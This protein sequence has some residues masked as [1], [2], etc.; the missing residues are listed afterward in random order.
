MSKDVYSNRNI[1]L[2]F[3]ITVSLVVMLCIF[4][5]PIADRLVLQ[6]NIF[7]RYYYN[8]RP[9]IGAILPSNGYSGKNLLSTITSDPYVP[10][11]SL[12]FPEEG[13]VSATGEYDKSNN[14]IQISR[15]K[16][17]LEDGEYIFTDGG[18]TVN[19]TVYYTYIAGYKNGEGE[20]VA[21]LPDNNVFVADGLK[22]D[23]YI[24]YLK[25][26]KGFYLDGVTFYPMIRKADVSDESFEP[27]VENDQGK[28]LVFHIHKKDYYALSKL[29]KYIFLHNLMYINNK[30]EWVSV[31]FDDETG[32]QF[33]FDELHNARYGGIDKNGRI[34]DSKTITNLTWESALGD[35][36]ILK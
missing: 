10:G 1:K 17:Y 14:T 25:I 34:N 23:Y 28:A 32:I 8:M 35:V 33:L 31:L 5:P 12:S 9:D 7:S 30:Y 11:F 15:D 18:K 13:S 36:N 4:Y 27:H 22:Y 20:V 3:S 26:E 6:E 2:F 29:E 16:V 21:S 19:H 24:V